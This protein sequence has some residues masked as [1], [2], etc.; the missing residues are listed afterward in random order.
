MRTIHKFKPGSIFNNRYQLLN[1]VGVGGFAEV[2][3]AFDTFTKQTIAIK[4]YAHLDDEGK[5]QLTE[6]YAR[7]QALSHPN[8]LK[9]EH[10]D[11]CNNMP[12]LT[13][14]YCA[15]GSLENQIGQLS[16]AEMMWIVRDIMS[17]LHYLHTNGIVHQDIKPA[18]ILIDTTGKRPRYLLCDFGISSRTRNS[19]SRSIKDNK[20]GA[21]F[22]T[23]FYAP[24]EK[25]SAKKSE[26]SPFPEG[27]IFSFG[28]TLLELTGTLVNID[29]SLGAEMMNNSNIEV[30]YNVLPSLPLQSM[31]Q[32]MLL[33]ERAARG[34]A[35]MYFDKSTELL[36]KS[37]SLE[38]QQNQRIAM[39]NQQQETR[40]QKVEDSRRKS[41]LYRVH[42]EDITSDPQTDVQEKSVANAGEEDIIVIDDDNSI[43]PPISLKPRKIALS[44]SSSD[45]NEVLDY[46][47]QSTIKQNGPHLV[48][49]RNEKKSHLWIIIILAIA[50]AATAAVAITI[51]TS[52]NPDT[53]LQEDDYIPDA[54]INFVEAQMTRLS[55]RVSNFANTRFYSDSDYN[56]QY[57]S[58]SGEINLTLKRCNE[59]LN[60][61][62]LEPYQRKQIEA[63][64]DN[65]LELQKSMSTFVY[66][67]GETQITK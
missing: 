60:H 5:R 46:N 4:I 19:L 67:S 32:Q 58:I 57:K 9:A 30:N 52:S 44:P 53:E 27:D 25:F 35:Q 38:R 12:Y 51:W 49:I 28:V 17:A 37:P 31:T 39:L 55:N 43:T 2:W 11:I 8:I 14:R 13:M 62:G 47:T 10:F 22:M 29:K 42:G 34:T 1:L 36:E 3:K 26:R 7:V 48:K 24:P 15:G 61:Y 59:I 40:L 20:P 18:N 21:I 54:D 23:T 41:E 45:G 33:F 65:L 66:I 16:A 56:Q 6:E 63:D 50:L 64:R